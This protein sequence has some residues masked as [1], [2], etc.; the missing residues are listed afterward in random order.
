[1]AEKRSIYLRELTWEDAKA[2]AADNATIVLPAGSIE[3]HGPHLP[4]ETDSRLVWE[5]ARRAVAQIA[6]RVNIL[7]TP[8]LEFGYSTHHREFPG[9]MTLSGTTYMTVIVELCESLLRNGFRRIFILN[10]HGGNSDPIHMAVRAIRDKYDDVLMGT[11]A[12][13]SIASKALSH[14][15]ESPSGGMSHAC[16]LEASLMWHLRPELVKS[17]RFAKRITRWHNPLLRDDLL[18]SG[19]VRLAFH[20]PDVTPLG[21]Q[22]DPTLAS[23]EK[24]EQFLRLIVD[25]VAAFLTDFSRWDLKHLPVS[26][27]TR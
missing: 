11:A 1:M 16:E 17:D 21:F 26:F 3:Q 12:Y 20:F 15:R 9:T 4:V 2:R 5:V 6:D 8:P 13:W 10:G 7:V 19:S 27:D 25:E 23:Q 24:G 18:D 14:V 22:G